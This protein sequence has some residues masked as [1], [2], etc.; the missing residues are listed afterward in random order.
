MDVISILI[1]LALGFVISYVIFNLLNKTKN[2]SKADFDLL[3]EK[4]NDTNTQLKVFEDRL[5][6]QQQEYSK[7]NIKFETRENEINSLKQKIAEEVAKNYALTENYNSIK[8]TS[9]KQEEQIIKLAE[10]NNKLNSENS[11]LTANNST[12]HEKLST[13]KEE[14]IEI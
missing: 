1:G 10:L 4:F 6:S 13:Q 3:T 2:V 9:K 11:S 7:L 8:E 12:L 14:I 5:L